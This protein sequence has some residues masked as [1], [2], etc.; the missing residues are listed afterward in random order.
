MMI[1]RIVTAEHGIRDLEVKISEL[2]NK[3]WRPAGGITFNQG[4]CYQAMIGKVS[5]K[6]ENADVQSIEQGQQLGANEAMKRLD[7]IL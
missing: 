1:Y 6:P 7:D 5:K 4:F 3:G 2:L